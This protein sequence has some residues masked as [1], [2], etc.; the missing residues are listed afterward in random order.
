MDEVI[1]KEE[2]ASPI[3]AT[4][5][6]F[7]QYSGPIPPPHFLEAYERLVPGSAKR[8]LDEPHVEAEHRRDLEKQVVGSS[9]KLAAK[10]QILA[11]IL[12]LLCLIAAFYAIFLGYSLG[13]LGALFISIASFAGIFL[14]S[15]KK[16]V[17]TK[18]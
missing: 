8:F 12:A 6:A 4:I 16:Q 18:N 7:Q 1:A 13:G 9:I 15:R 17:Q 3:S 14:F 5:A 11:F 2:K 10:G